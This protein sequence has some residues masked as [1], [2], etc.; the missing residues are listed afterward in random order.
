MSAPST[1]KDLAR[2]LSPVIE[3]LANLRYLFHHYPKY[4]VSLEE[5]ESD[6][7]ERLLRLIREALVD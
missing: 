5:R 6:A 4:R 1:A 3:E 7:F 2:E